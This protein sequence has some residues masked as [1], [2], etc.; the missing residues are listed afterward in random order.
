MKLF[1]VCFNFL[2]HET[3]SVSFFKKHLSLKILSQSFQING[4]QP[5]G[6]K[7]THIFL[8][9]DSSNICTC[10][11]SKFL[12]LDYVVFLLFICWNSSSVIDLLMLLFDFFIFSSLSVLKWFRCI[13]SCIKCLSTHCQIFLIWFIFVNC[14]C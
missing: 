6:H 9:I 8:H 4:K 10:L 12:I 7:F 14:H 3:G 5:S 11:S 1:G 13:C 2:W